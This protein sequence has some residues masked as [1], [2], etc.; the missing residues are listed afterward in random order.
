MSAIGAGE[1]RDVLL[2]GSGE[3]LC[4][5]GASA[6]L[7]VAL[8]LP[9]GLLVYLSAPRAPLGHARLLHTLLGALINVGRSMPFIILLVAVIPLTRLIAGT[10]LGTTAAIVPLTLAATP[11]YARV[12]Q[13]ALLE[14]DQGRIEAVIAMGGTL[15]QIILKVLL[16]EALPGLVAGVTLTS[17]VLVS[18]SAMAG[19]VG[20]GGLGDLAVRYGYER[21]NTLVML[22]TVV[23]LIVLVQIIQTAG[24]HLVR[25]LA[26][27]R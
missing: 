4:M 24:D 14:V 19:V 25:R 13:T 21:F 27:R 18:F 7:T 15:T 17:V 22:A 20:G 6:L 3:T 1:L 16:P 5:V 10:S 26:H 11:F 8:G 23:V 12:V 2:T 9:L